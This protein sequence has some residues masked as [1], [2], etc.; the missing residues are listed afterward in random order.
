MS[1]LEALQNAQ[2][3]AGDTPWGA[4]FGVVGASLPGLINPYGKVGTNIGIALGGSLLTS[5]LGYQ[6]KKQALEENMAMRPL[7]RELMSATTGE[8]ADAILAKP[9]GNRLQEFA[10]QLEMSRLQQAAA[11]AQAEQ[12]F[13]QKALLAGIQ[14]GYVA[15]EQFNQLGVGLPGMLP[16]ASLQASPSPVVAKLP[17]PVPTKE[18]TPTA[19]TET[20]TSGLPLENVYDQ[21]KKLVGEAPKVDVIT[22]EDFKLPRILLDRKKAQIEDQQK[23]RANYDARFKQAV[24]GIQSNYGNIREIGSE[25]IKSQTVKDYDLVSRYNKQIRELAANPTRANIDQLIALTKKSV[26]PTSV[27]TLGEY[28]QAE[29][30]QSAIDKWKQSLQNLYTATPRI[31]QEAVKQMVEASDVITDVL[32]NAYNDEISRTQE[33]AGALNM[34]KIDP[35]MLGVKPHRGAMQIE[36]ELD[37]VNAMI[38]SDKAKSNPQFLQKALRAKEELRQEWQ[39]LKN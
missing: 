35:K 5:L 18:A 3:Q 34:G 31:Q 20:N 19:A 22:E 21:A 11:K 12:E 7:V 37:K 14:G 1:L 28:K 17:E 26:D 36:S 13:R 8:Q 23:E 29:D 39:R 2:V 27:V 6:A 4:G 33:R 10:T 32:G 9:G 30:V 25:L 16:A 38:N 15:P 24:E